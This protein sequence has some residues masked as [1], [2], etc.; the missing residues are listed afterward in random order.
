MLHRNALNPPPHQ[1]PLLLILILSFFHSISHPHSLQLISHSILLYP[2]Y[3]RLSGLIEIEQKH[4]L[5]WNVWMSIDLETLQWIYF[6]RYTTFFICP[7]SA[8]MLGWWM[9]LCLLLFCY[10]FVLFRR[11]DGEKWTWSETK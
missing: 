10:R 5:L 9:V 11:M 1:T 6:S 3:T 7:D 2:H 4:K 8:D